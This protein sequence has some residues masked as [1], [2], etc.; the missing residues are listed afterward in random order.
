MEMRKVC[1]IGGT[2]F[3]GHYIL[4]RL[5]RAG[6]PSR[7]LCRHP[8]RHADLQMV[9]GVELRQT[10]LFDPRQ[11]D[12]GL[13]G[14]DALIQLLGILNESR[15]AGSFQHLH[16]ALVDAVIDACQRN[17]VQRLLHMSALHADEYRGASA[18]LRSK[19]AGENHAHARGQPDIRVTSFRPSVIFGAGDS[20]FNRFAGLLRLAPGVFPLACPTSRFAPV[21][22]GDVAEAFVR[23]LHDPT[24]FGGR[25]DLCGPRIFT[26]RELV[27]YTARQIRRPLR[28]IGLSD[29]LARLQARMLGLVPGKPFT[30]DNYLSLQTDSV[31]SANGL[32]QLGI[33]PTD[34]DTIVPTYLADAGERRRYQSL[35]RV[36]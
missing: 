17:G 26:L 3:V 20:F 13:T 24:T 33:T 16:V 8:Q 30:M 22:A 19:G 1:V 28:I 34:I 5:A 12:A 31:C 23:S 11:L 18:Y 29:P 14:C 7:V 2:G 21:Y 4:R 25:F 36:Y 27:E 15:V 6:I 32:A 35:R 10:D 9:P